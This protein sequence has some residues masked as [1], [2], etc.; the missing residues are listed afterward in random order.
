MEILQY[1][2]EHR[3][4]RDSVRRFFDKEVVPHVEQW[5]EDGIVPRE[6]WNKLGD[7]GYLGISL[8]EKYGGVEAD[9]LY[10]VILMEE[11]VRTNHYG[12]AIFLHNDIVVPYINDYG[13]EEQKQR[14]LP[15]CI[16]GEIITAVAMT[17]PDTGSDLAAVRTSAVEDGDS[18]VINGQKTFISNGIIS[19]LV[20]LVT[21]DPKV[22]NPHQSIDL[23]LVEAGTPGFEKGKKLNKIGWR[24]QDTAELFFNDCRVPK[25]SRLGEKGQGFKILMDKL[26]PERLVLCI[27]SVAMA[28]NI[29]DQTIKYCQDRKAFG[30]PL[31]SFQNSQFK[32][33]EMA[34]EVKIGK[35]FVDQLIFDYM[36]GQDVTME[37]SMGKFW[38]TE[39]AQR[40]IDGC[41][42][43]HGGY[44][45]CEEYPVARAW[46]D[47]RV[48]SIFAGTNE[49]MKTIVAKKMNL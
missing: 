3:I 45:Y 16:T 34:T 1:T 23:Y 48:M 28:G 44:G 47:A 35:A 49:I 12:L 29:L 31:S 5:E 8:E 41:L 30:K 39:M 21:R 10:S 26:Q 20:V 32:L 25:A 9:F 43:L 38:T 42:Q 40:V 36:Q 7:Q 4:F 18:V 33:V 17:E 2:Q 37:I 6:M 11:L 22:E 46:R 13:N 24:S 27:A 15:G 19:D 14:Y